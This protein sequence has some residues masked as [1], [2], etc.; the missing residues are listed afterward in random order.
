MTMPQV[1]FKRGD[2]WSQV[3]TWATADGDPID[4]SGCSARQQFRTDTGLVIL[5]ASSTDGELEIQP[6]VDGEVM[7]GKVYLRLDADATAEA[8]IGV[9]YTDQ[10]LTFPDTTVRSTETYRV[11]VVQDQTR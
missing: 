8:R 9:L 4:L 5:E 2:T 1:T 11:K 6:T 3:F 10:E 7:T